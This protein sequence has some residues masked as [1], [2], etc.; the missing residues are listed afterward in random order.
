MEFGKVQHIDNID[1]TLPPDD[2]VTEELWRRSKGR[3]AE[4]L[5]IYVGGTE[6]GRASWVGTVYPQGTKSKDFLT[7]YGKQFNTVELN[8]IFYGLPTADTVRRWASAVNERFQFCPKFP[9][10]ISHQQ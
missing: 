3:P 10:V 6:W 5:R 9:E 2:L 1:F 8:T 7:F 4:P